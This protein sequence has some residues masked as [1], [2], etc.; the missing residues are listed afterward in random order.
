MSIT[1][2][3]PIHLSVQNNTDLNFDQTIGNCCSLRVSIILDKHCHGLLLSVLKSH[4]QRTLKP[5]FA[6]LGFWQL[7][8]QTRQAIYKDTSWEMYLFHKREAKRPVLHCGRHRRRRH[9][10]TLSPVSKRLQSNY[11]RTIHFSTDARLAL[12]RCAALQ[13]SA[14]TEILLSTTAGEGTAPSRQA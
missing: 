14:S 3:P 9:K 8:L 10:F 1:A 6:T 5:T 13:R 7:V 11:S 2:L 4:C 12:N